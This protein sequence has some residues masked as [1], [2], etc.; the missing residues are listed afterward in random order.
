MIAHPTPSEI[1]AIIRQK[2][3]GQV[4]S[5]ECKHATYSVAVDGAQDALTVKE[6]IT[7]KDGTRLPTVRVIENYKRP[8]WVTKE[9][10]RTHPDKIQVEEVKRL[11]KFMCRQLDLTRELYNRLRFGNPDW[12]VRKLARKPYIYG[13]D[14]GSEVYL[15][16]QYMEKWPGCFVP[17][18]VTVIDCETDVWDEGFKPILWSEVNDD[19]IILYYSRKWAWV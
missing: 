3:A 14:F 11:D 16:N 9:P 5:R 4:K 19:E 17:N 8:A 2:G 7:F 1:D 6:W 10:Y 12:N 18:L 13:C 15:K